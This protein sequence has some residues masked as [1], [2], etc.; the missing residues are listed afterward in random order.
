MNT[1]PSELAGPGFKF[2][3][4]INFLSGLSCTCF[5]GVGNTVDGAAEF[6]WLNGLDKFARVRVEALHPPVFPVSHANQ[7]LVL[8][9]G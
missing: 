5:L 4:S 3:K 8:S 7:V 9:E 6:C 1:L 2:I